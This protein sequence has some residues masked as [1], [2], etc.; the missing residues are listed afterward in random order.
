SYA[1]HRALHSFPTRRSSD[2]RYPACPTMRPLSM[3]TAFS[4]NIVK[5]FLLVLFLATYGVNTLA[6]PALKQTPE[7]E[8]AA[9]EIVT[10]L[11]KK[12]YRNQILNDDLSARFL[13]DYLKALDPAKNYFLKSD[14]DEFEKHRKKFDDYLKKG[15]LTQG[16]AIFNRYNERVEKRLNAI[17]AQLAD[18]T[19]KYDFDVEESIS[20]DWKNAQWPA[21][22]KEADALW[23]K[24]IKFNL[25][26]LMLTGKTVEESK[27]ILEK[28][29]KNQLRRVKQQDS[30][31]VF[32]LMMNSLTM[33]YDPHTNY[34]SPRNAEN[35]NINMALSLEGIGAVLQ[36]E[37]EYTKVMRLVPAGPAAKQGELKPADRIIAIGQGPTGEMVDV[38]GWRLD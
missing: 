5:P 9:V 19:V 11:E 13:E 29:F 30:E 35:F 4:R 36:S 27:T 24:R 22:Q 7:Q 16:F 38:V 21:N 25:L 34:L 31:E 23:Q 28:R 3:Y 18:E 8:K 15:D 32:S 6:L 2:L 10:Q 14:I 1:D 37:D 26:N 20:T 33:L 17:L 12:H